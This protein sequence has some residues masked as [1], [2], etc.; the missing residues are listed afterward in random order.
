M[1]LVKMPLGHFIEFVAFLAVNALK[2]Y[3]VCVSSSPLG[4]SE[5]SKR[6]LR[7]TWLLSDP[8]M[9]GNVQLNAIR[10]LIFRHLYYWH[11]RHLYFGDHNINQVIWKFCLVQ[12][13]H[14][15]SSFNIFLLSVSSLLNFFLQILLG[16]LVLSHKTFIWKTFSQQY[17]NIR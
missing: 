5:D 2:F 16:N 1:Q 9:K 15:H 12:T 14:S 8:R 4:A 13:S 10:A 11:Y 17:S 3:L 6:R 7:L